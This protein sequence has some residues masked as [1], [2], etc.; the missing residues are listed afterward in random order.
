MSFEADVSPEPP[1]KNAGVL[2]LIV[3]LSEFNILFK[4]TETSCFS[5]CT[6]VIFSTLRSLF[7]VIYPPWSSSLVSA[8]MLY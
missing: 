4:T 7:S 2:E 5:D 6:E 3:L 8:Q 1:V